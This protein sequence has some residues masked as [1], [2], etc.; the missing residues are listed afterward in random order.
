MQ[1]HIVF[2][3]LFSVCRSITVL[4]CVNVIQSTTY[5]LRVV[6]WTSL[7]DVGR[8]SMR[9]SERHSIYYICV[10]C[11]YLDI[12][13]RRGEKQHERKRE[14]VPTASQIPSK[15]QT[16]IKQE[17]LAVARLLFPTSNLLLPSTIYN[18]NSDGYL[19]HL[20]STGPKRAH[21]L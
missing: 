4:S 12:T 13:K 2:V 21:T 3:L 10:M 7:K 19:E 5:A 8:N 18:N 14:A 20:T 17:P 15:E 11:C 16:R 9:E 1:L 6:I